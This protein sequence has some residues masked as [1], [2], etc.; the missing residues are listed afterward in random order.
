MVSL[1]ASAASPAPVR[2]SCRAVGNC[3]AGA[4]AGSA[5]EAD[6]EVVALPDAA[7]VDAGGQIGDSAETWQLGAGIGIEPRHED[8]RALVRTRVRQRQRGIGACLRVAGDD[9]DVERAWSPP[10]RPNPAACT[11]GRMAPVEQ[12]ARW[13]RADR[14]EH[15][16]QVVGLF[17]AADGARLVHAGDGRCPDLPISGQRVDAGLEA[18]KPVAQVAAESEYDLALERTRHHVRPRLIVTLTSRTGTPTGAS[19]L[20]TVTSACSTR[21]SARH[22]AASR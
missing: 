14:D 15:R 17:R 13:Q 1:A 7:I 8:E 12:C 20:W 2:R 21:A 19:G 11:L 5:A 10:D 22:S 4:P 6:A 18:P 9:V 16:V 3:A